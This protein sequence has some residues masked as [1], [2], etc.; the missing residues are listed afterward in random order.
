[1]CFYCYGQTPPAVGRKRFAPAPDKPTLMMVD[2]IRP[3]DDDDGER[4]SKRMRERGT[5]RGALPRR[6]PIILI[7]SVNAVCAALATALFLHSTSSS[8]PPS[9]NGDDATMTTTAANVGRARVAFAACLGAAS[10][11]AGIVYGDSI[12]HLLAFGVGV[13]DDDE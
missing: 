4:R 11:S 10:T 13:S 1:M 12:A 6:V 5:P 9:G 7:A 3:A 2:A 8:S